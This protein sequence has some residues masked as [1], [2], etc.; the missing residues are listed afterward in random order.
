MRRHKLDGIDLL[1]RRFRVPG[2]GRGHLL[3]GGELKKEQMA[4]TVAC[5]Y[6]PS[7]FLFGVC[8]EIFLYSFQD[9]T[10]V[11]AVL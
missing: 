7:T 1:H 10:V 2:D 8:V 9:T 4:R 6:N 5:T 3:L 11:D